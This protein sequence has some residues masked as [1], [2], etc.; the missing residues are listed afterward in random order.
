[1]KVGV[2]GGCWLTFTRTFGDVNASLGPA[3]IDGVKV[4]KHS[5]LFLQMIWESC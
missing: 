5:C 1:M 2:G 3:G 4:H